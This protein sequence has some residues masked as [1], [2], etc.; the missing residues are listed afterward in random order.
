MPK[1][2]FYYWKNKKNTES[3]QLCLNCMY[4]LHHASSCLAFTA[5]GSKLLLLTVWKRLKNQIAQRLI[6]SLFAA[7][8]L[9]RFRFSFFTP[10]MVCA[11]KRIKKLLLIRIF[12]KEDY[13]HVIGTTRLHKFAQGQQLN[14]FHLCL[15]IFAKFNITLI[16]HQ[17]NYFLDKLMPRGLLPLNVMRA[18][19][20]F[21]LPVNS[22]TAAFKAPQQTLF[23][24]SRLPGVCS[25][26]MPN[27]VLRKEKFCSFLYKLLFDIKRP[28]V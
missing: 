8:R 20:S 9:I 28:T 21:I 7:G 11:K 10:L 24:R 22:I 12:S 26:K 18:E 14:K 6:L 25:W 27:S 13:L 17:R 16:D 5:K 4:P 23:K 2:H 1:N 19:L 3:A 15:L